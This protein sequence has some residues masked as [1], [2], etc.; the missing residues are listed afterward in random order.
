M[1]N[2]LLAA[3]VT[4]F[5]SKVQESCEQTCR[6]KGNKFSKV[7]VLVYFLCKVTR[8]ASKLLH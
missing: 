7:S 1:Y 6:E 8:N 2:D 4:F 5:K 3:R